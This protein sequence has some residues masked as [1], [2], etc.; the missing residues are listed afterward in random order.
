MTIV[1]NDKEKIQSKKKKTAKQILKF[2]VVNF[3]KELTNYNFD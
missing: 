2:K 3:Y 1:R